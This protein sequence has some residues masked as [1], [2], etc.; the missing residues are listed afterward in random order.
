MNHN[1]RSIVHLVLF[2]SFLFPALTNSQNVYN[3]FLKEF[4]L[5]RQPSAKA[6]E[7]GRGLVAYPEYDFSSWY[8]P[9]TVGLSE[10]ITAQYSSINVPNSSNN[11]A[12]FND[13]N[14]S[15]NS[16]KYGAIGISANSLAFTEYTTLCV[17]EPSWKYDMHNLNY[18]YQPYRNFFTGINLNVLS[19]N[20]YGS[21]QTLYPIDIGALKILELPKISRMLQKI[22]LG[23]SVYNITNVKY[24]KK[25]F[26]SNILQPLPVILRVDTSYNIQYFETMSPISERIVNLL[27]HFEYE[28]LL[29]S[30]LFTTYKAGVDIAFVDLIAFRL[31][32]FT[33]KIEDDSYPSSIQHQVTYG[34]GLKFPVSKWSDGL[35]P[36]NARLEFAF[37]EQPSLG[38]FY[39]MSD[40][41]TFN[42]SIRWEKPVFNF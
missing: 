30:G 42:L 1:Y 27:C 2:I 12:Y 14:V 28:N 20:T 32:Y 22:T 16:G 35:I 23:S 24:N 38:G 31:G 13:F 17:G 6:I 21:S 5:D 40:L 36:I 29:N 8:N 11:E 3:G 7:M 15:F 37:N 39:H 18:A 19:I 4:Y 26:D 10:T 34:I 33:R 41:N 9:A 25:Y